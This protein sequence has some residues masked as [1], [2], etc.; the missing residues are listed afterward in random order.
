[1][2]L[3]GK[4]VCAARDFL[5]I[6]TEKFV[7]EIK[8]MPILDAFLLVFKRKSIYTAKNI[9]KITILYKNEHLT[10]E[11]SFMDKFKHK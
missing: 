11:F 8:N 9:T 3:D 7:R 5:I 2:I 10:D 4:I 6:Y 1:M